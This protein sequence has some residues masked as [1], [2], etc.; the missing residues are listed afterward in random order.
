MEV[1]YKY[2]KNTLMV[3]SFFS[4]KAPEVLC[5]PPVKRSIRKKDT[6]PQLYDNRVVAWSVGV[7]AYEVLVGFSPFDGTWPLPSAMP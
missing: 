3:A 6:A 1:Y 5:C 7:L 4:P 2:Y